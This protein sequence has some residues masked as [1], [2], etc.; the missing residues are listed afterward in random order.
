[1]TLRGHSTFGKSSHFWESPQPAR[2]D[3]PGQAHRTD[4]KTSKVNKRHV[5][6]HAVCHLY[7]ETFFST[8]VVHCYTRQQQQKIRTHTHKAKTK[9]I[10]NAERLGTVSEVHGC[11][12]YIIALWPNSNSFSYNSFDIIDLFVYNF[13]LRPLRRAVVAFLYM[14]CYF[15]IWPLWFLRFIYDQLVHQVYPT[16]L[17]PHVKFVS[18][19]TSSLQVTD[20]SLWAFGTP[21][22]LFEMG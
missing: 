10:I 12:A 8:N 3:L 14:C 4:N 7:T 17:N 11:L 16:C 15:R 18:Y 1:M 13:C 19:T 21:F 5:T 2:N 9:R 20:T 6:F 22:L